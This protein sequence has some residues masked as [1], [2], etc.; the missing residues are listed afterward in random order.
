MIRNRVDPVPDPKP[1]FS[2]YLIDFDFVESIGELVIEDK[3]VTVHYV[4]PLR[5]LREHTS[6]TTRQRLKENR[7]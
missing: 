3:L 1:S 4:L 2:C 7:S 5:Y 6:L